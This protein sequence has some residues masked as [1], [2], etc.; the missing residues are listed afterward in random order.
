[1]YGNIY[2]FYNEA[3]KYLAENCEQYA[4]VVTKPYAV[5][6]AG[7]MPDKEHNLVFYRL[8]D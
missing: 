5:R 6:L 2:L 1:M 8:L 3:K 7:R 4:S